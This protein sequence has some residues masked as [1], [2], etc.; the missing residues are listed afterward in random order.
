MGVS[1]IRRISRNFF[2]FI[3]LVEDLKGFVNI[4]IIKRGIQGFRIYNF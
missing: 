3:G 2:V 1:V 4:S